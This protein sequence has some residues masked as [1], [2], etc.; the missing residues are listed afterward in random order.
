MEP[1]NQRR[2][3][4]CRLEC[5][6]GKVWDGGGTCDTACCLRCLCSGH[7]GQAASCSAGYHRWEAP[8]RARHEHSHGGV[9]GVSKQQQTQKGQEITQSNNQKDAKASVETMSKCCSSS[10]WLE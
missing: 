9:I 3:S 8:S 10:R 1:G 6:S 4:A 5:G 7:K 2:K